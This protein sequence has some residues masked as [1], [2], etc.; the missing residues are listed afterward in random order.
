MTTHMFLRLP[1]DCC[2][3]PQKWEVGHVMAIFNDKTPIGFAGTKT[4]C[5][6]DFL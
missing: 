5:R 4:I 6:G 2:W 1:T 3:R